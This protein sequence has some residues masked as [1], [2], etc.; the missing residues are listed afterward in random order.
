MFGSPSVKPMTQGVTFS[1]T[2]S[3]AAS[4]IWRLIATGLSVML[5]PSLT[6]SRIFRVG[7]SATLS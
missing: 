2:A 3:S 1:A 5:L 4:V 7:S 6:K